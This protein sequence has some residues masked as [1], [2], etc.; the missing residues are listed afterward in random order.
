MRWIFDL[1]WLALLLFM[2]ATWRLMPEMV[3]EAHKA[4][5]RDQH[6]AL[7]MGVALWCPWL[8][9]RGAMWLARVFPAGLNIPNKAFWLAT[10]GAMW[11]ARV[12]PA[13]LNIPNKAFWLATRG[14]MWLARV[15]PAG[16]NIP[17]KAF[18]LE[19]ERRESSLDWL[20][21]QCFALGLGVV[22]VFATLHYIS[23]QPAMPGWPALPGELLTAG[24][25]GLLA[26][27]TGWGIR[28]HRHFSAVPEPQ[29]AAPP[30]RTSRNDELVWREVQPMWA[31]LI[32][33]PL[34]AMGLL[35]AT[36][37]QNGGLSLE[38]G[39]ASTLLPVL[40]MLCLGL[41]RLVTEVRGD[42]LVWRFGW[43]GWPRWRVPLDQIAAVE[44]AHSTVLEGWGIR[45]TR[46]GMLYNAHGRQAVRLTLRSGR[47][48]RLGTRDAQRLLQALRPRIADS[49]A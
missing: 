12:F 34:V 43:L 10:R 33:L 9:T 45:L 38:N 5:P 7:M 27:F 44:A 48:L 6:M 36:G 15:F 49:D 28:L 25:I 20:R 35:V 31:L 2:A 39:L 22:L 1:A 24:A 4:L 8:A 3:G 32:L 47:Q 37:W 19:P 26:G 21:E 17:N 30:S 23:L 11:L 46:E 16:L 29:R 41:G 42:A 18:W 13:G 40:A 14:A